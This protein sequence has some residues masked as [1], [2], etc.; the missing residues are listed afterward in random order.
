MKRDWMW[1]W[2]AFAA[3]G[4]LAAATVKGIDFTPETR[5]M[6]LAL[7]MGLAGGVGT[8][9][10]WLRNRHSVRRIVRAGGEAELIVRPVDAAL[11]ALRTYPAFFGSLILIRLVVGSDIDWAHDLIFAAVMAYGLNLDWT[12]YRKPA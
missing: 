1:G 11:R 6:G 3:T 7:V 2:I 9:V 8:L 10:L 5:W 12:A 4:F